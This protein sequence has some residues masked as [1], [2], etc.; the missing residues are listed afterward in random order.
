MYGLLGGGYRLTPGERSLSLSVE[1][2]A[3]GLGD[4]TAFVEALAVPPEI[5]IVGLPRELAEAVLDGVEQALEDGFGLGP[6]S[7]HLACAAHGAIGST[8][9]GFRLLARTVVGLISW[10]SCSES[11]VRD[12]V[13]SLLM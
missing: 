11:E 6:G 1:Y 3:G 2:S 9:V 12:R 5:A 13:S 8:P 7:L 10:G 4:G